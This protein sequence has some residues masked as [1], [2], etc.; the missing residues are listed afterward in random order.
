M[1]RRLRRPVAVWPQRWPTVHQ[2]ATVRDSAVQKA[3]PGLGLSAQ[4]PVAADRGVEQVGGRCDAVVPRQRWP[5]AVSCGRPTAPSE[6]VD[7][8]GKAVPCGPRHGRARACSL[9]PTLGAANP[10]P[11]ANSTV[12]RRASRWQSTDLCSPWCPG[13]DA[14]H[15]RESVL[16]RRSCSRH[17]ADSLNPTRRAAPASSCGP[18]AATTAAV[19]R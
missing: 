13:A 5:G 12:P 4:L 18:Q 15:R 1:L 3:K 2:L 17:A 8:R 19:M 16:M 11:P 7:R 14:G 10:R 6:R 9:A